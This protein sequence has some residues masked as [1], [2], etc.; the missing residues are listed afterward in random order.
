[1]TQ[2]I[3]T[4][5][6]PR[7]HV[8]LPVLI[9]AQTDTCE[10][11]VPGLVS[12]ISRSGMELYGGVQQRPGD[13]MEVEFHASGSMRIAGVVRNRSGYCFGL[14]FL[15]LMTSPPDGANA[16]RLGSASGRDGWRF[17]FGALG[18][19]QRASS[20]SGV[21][22]EEIV[23]PEGTLAALIL[24]RHDEYLRQMQLEI[25]RLRQRAMKIRQWRQEMEP[26]LHEGRMSR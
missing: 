23:G 1:M 9:S 25:H 15:S 21:G 20:P 8:H 5:R 2:R 19:E 4:R 6:W 26:F 14:E 12:E 16:P 18:I 17:A 3:K 10:V 24:E 22:D 11:A 7:F 13:L